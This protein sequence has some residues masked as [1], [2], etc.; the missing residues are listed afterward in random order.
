MYSLS[1][2]RLSCVTVLRRWI[3]QKEKKIDNKKKQTAML[4][5]FFMYTDDVHASH[6]H[7]SHVRG[8]TRDVRYASS[9][10]FTE[11]FWHRVTEM[12]L[13]NYSHISHPALYF[14]TPHL[15]PRRV[16]QQYLS[17][18]IS[19]L[20]SALWQMGNET[21]LFLFLQKRYEIPVEE[22]VTTSRLIVEKQSNAYRSLAR[23]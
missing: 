5:R 2:Q 14:S 23:I 16:C 13:Q 22:K 8:T 17:P 4:S 3:K 9:W 18:N 19:L 20:L 7:V 11:A 1:S 21:F 10:S 12:Q 6:V 15:C